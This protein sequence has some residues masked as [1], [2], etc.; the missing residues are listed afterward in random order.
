MFKKN[1]SINPIEALCLAFYNQ[2]KVVGM[3]RTYFGWL[4]KK[5]NS[6][7]LI[8]ALCL[9]LYNQDKVVGRVF[10]PQWC[11]QEYKKYLMLRHYIEEMAWAMPQRGT[12]QK[13]GT[14]IYGGW[15]VEQLLESHQ[16][17]AWDYN[18]YCRCIYSA[19]KIFV[20]RNTSR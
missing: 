9:A 2:D 1:N 5:N 8:E 6:V 7:T 11:E 16:S 20:L 18:N 12:Q 3:M 14:S 17:K 10:L 4:F 19:P 13:W 15:L